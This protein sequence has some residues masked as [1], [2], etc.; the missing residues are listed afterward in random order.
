MANLETTPLDCRPEADDAPKEKTRGFT[1]AE[2][3]VALAIMGMVTM[4]ALPSFA[5]FG[6][7]IAFAFG[8][9]E[10]LRMRKCDSRESDG[11]HQAFQ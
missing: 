9:Q 6:D 7:R 1:L 8:R 11:F 10:F 3:L 2:L 4:L 5:R